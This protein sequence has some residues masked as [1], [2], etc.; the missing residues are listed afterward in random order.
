MYC[1][2]TNIIVEATRKK[3]PRLAQIL[4]HF[5]NVDPSEIVVPAIVVA[6]LEFGARHSDNYEQNMKIISDFISAYQIIPFAQAEAVAYGSI[7]QQLTADGKPIGSNDML[8]AATALAYNA[9]VVT[10]NVDEF[11]RVRGLTVVDWQE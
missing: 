10:H 8:I 4:E 5:H 3:N 1:L 2:D 9:T 7:R 6:E 11:S